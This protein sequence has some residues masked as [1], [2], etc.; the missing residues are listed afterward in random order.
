MWLTRSYCNLEPV[1]AWA[2][3]GTW[4]WPRPG[5]ESPSFHAHARRPPTAAATALDGRLNG[6][7]ANRQAAAGCIPCALWAGNGSPE[8]PRLR[9]LRSAAAATWLRSGQRTSHQKVFP[10]RRRRSQ[11]TAAPS[12]TAPSPCSTVI[13]GRAAARSSASSSALPGT[14]TMGA[15]NAGQH[16]HRLIQPLPRIAE[17]AGPDHQ[18]CLCH[19][20]LQARRHDWRQDA[21]RRNA[22]ILRVGIRGPL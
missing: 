9:T 14:T 11:R 10:A 21:D 16:L 5:R 6:G 19:W 22:R 2:K 1:R 12:T 17:I 3:I 4:S 8:Y 7:G 18:I 20:P 15:R 13:F